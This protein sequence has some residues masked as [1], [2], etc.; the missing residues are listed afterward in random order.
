MSAFSLHLK[1]LCYILLFSQ[2]YYITK[3]SLKPANKQYSS[4]RNDYEMSLN[5]DT[6]IEL[7]SLTLKVDISNV[8]I[9]IIFSCANNIAIII[10]F[11]RKIL[12]R[13]AHANCFRLISGYISELLIMSSILWVLS[14]A[15]LI[16][17]CIL[18]KSI[19][20]FIENFFYE[21]HKKAEKLMGTCTCKFFYLK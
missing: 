18:E 8:F 19:F 13:K 12:V 4:L 15:R 5:N 6:I 2:V 11:F 16:F 10:L 1:P 20:S 21:F 3:A 14:I 9:A 7:V 17:F